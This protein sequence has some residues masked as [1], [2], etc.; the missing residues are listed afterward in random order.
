LRARLLEGAVGKSLTA[1][2]AGSPITGTRAAELDAT[3]ARL[4]LTDYGFTP[5]DDGPR[6]NAAERLQQFRRARAWLRT[7]ARTKGINPHAGSTYALKHR[8][9]PAIGWTAAG[10]FIA[11]AVAAGFA[12][13][14]C[15][16]SS[17]NAFVNISTRITTTL[18][19]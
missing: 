7:Q 2:V 1:R 6:L 19:A 10:I 13:R 14:R 16:A 5:C 4:G 9:E 18:A 8:A 17:P 3:L 15:N 11:A 12:V